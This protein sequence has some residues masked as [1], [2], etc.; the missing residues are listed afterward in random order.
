MCERRSS[1]SKRGVEAVRKAR[2]DAAAAFTA[3]G[4]GVRWPLLFLALWSRIHLEG[5]KP[6]EALASVVGSV[7]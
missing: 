4:D 7:G 2:P 3:G 6:A 1:P 5:A